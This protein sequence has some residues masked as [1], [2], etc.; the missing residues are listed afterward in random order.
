MGIKYRVNEDFFSE[1]TENMAYVLG[2]I[3]ADGNL[4]D[5]KYNRGQY[6]SIRSTD[7]CIIE[8]IR[9]SLNS[10][11]TITSEKNDFPRK[12]SYVLRI[13]SKK[14]FGILERR[15]LCPRKSL[16]ID[17]PSIPKIFFKDFLRGYFDG[18]GC[19]YLEKGKK[20]GS[21]KR[22]SVIFTSGSKKFLES[23]E[24]QIRKECQT[25]KRDVCDSHR[26]FQLR[27]STKDGLRVF[28]KM[29]KNQP[30]LYLSRKYSKFIQYIEIRNG[31]VVK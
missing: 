9:E 1:W 14:I 27:Y 24:K 6:V 5:S 10:E 15:G 29:Y 2:Y 21:F 11:H 22:M 13:G 16:I 26:S 23:L 25:S 3:Y 30:E 31:H 7:L 20:I 28:S 19:V 18:D 12:R 4:L 8:S 17:L